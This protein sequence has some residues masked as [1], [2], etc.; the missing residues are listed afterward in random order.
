M[1]PADFKAWRDKFEYRDSVLYLADCEEIAEEIGQHDA[2]LTD[3]PYGI[4]LKMG[5]VGGL[6][7]KNTR[8]EK[9]K[10]TTT[11]LIRHLL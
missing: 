5:T 11:P 2:V 9:S 4:G 8:G 3:P 7:K 6:A 1:T 10:A